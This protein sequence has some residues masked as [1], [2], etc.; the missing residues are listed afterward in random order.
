[1][2]SSELLQSI[3]GVY[4]SVAQFGDSSSETAR[5]HHIPG[6]RGSFGFISSMSDHFCGSCN[7]LRLTA[8]GQLKVRDAQRLRATVNK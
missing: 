3:K 5:M 6:Y 7:R 2:P 1:M 8:D 4:P